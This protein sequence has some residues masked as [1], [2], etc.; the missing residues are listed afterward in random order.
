[1]TRAVILAAGR[2]T[3]LA[4]LTDD[5]PKCLVELA[6]EPLLVHQARALRSA[7]VEDIRVVSGYRGDM[8]ADLGFPCITNRDFETTNMV[9]SLFCARELLDGETPLIVSYGDIVC[10]PEIVESLMQSDADVGVI[11][12]EDWLSLWQARNDDPLDD[13]ESLK[14]GDGDRILDIGDK[15]DSIDEIEA[16]YIG[17]MKFSPAVHARMRTL[18]DGLA[19]DPAWQFRGRDLTG[20]YMTDLLQY[21][22]DDDWDIR[23][24]RVHGGWLEVDTI[25]DLDTYHRMHDAGTLAAIAKRD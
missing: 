10:R 21:M 11:V 14:L 22:A 25:D 7:G 2:G 3:R 8:I 23:G 18:Y 1:M 5:R 20:L 12:D 17:L 19:A 16:Q 9:V 6:G 4:P 24:V 13:A 15:P